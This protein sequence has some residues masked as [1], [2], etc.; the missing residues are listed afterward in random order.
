MF[1]QKEDSIILI[2]D[3]VEISSL[4]SKKE[5]KAFLKQVWD[6]DQ[7][8]RETEMNVSAEFGY[9]SPEHDSIFEKWVNIDRYLFDKI[10]EYLS[11][12]PYPQRS[13][14][15]ASACF[16]PLIVFHH[17]AGIPEDIDLKKMYFSTFFKAYEQGDIYEGDLWMFLYRLYSQIKNE[18]YVNQELGDKGQIKEMIEILQLD[19]K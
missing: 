14:L 1:A 16:T 13:K 15:G 18:K 6:I 10:R 2:V 9:G 5:H 19:T 8:I 7:G 17:V 11:I 12:H 3:Q 4:S